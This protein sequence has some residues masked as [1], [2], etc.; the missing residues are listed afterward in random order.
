MAGRGLVAEL[1]RSIICPVCRGPFKDPVLLDC[2]HSYCRAC[3]TGYWEREGA[4][5]LS[6]PQCQ[7]VFERRSLRTHVKLAVEVKIAENLNAKMA[8][9]GLGTK[10]RRRRGGWIPVSVTPDGQGAGHICR[11]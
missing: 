1:Q 7:T 8:Q 2:D 4:G 11:C 9:E 10:P 6:C 5:V 3:I